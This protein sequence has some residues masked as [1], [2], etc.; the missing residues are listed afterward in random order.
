MYK[1]MYINSGINY[2]STGAGFVSINRMMDFLLFFLKQERNSLGL[3]YTIPFVKSGG[4]N[5]PGFA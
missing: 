3:Q 4:E 2:L 1:T 5:F